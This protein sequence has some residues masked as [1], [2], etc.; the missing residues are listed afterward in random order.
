VPRRTRSRECSTVEASWRVKI[1]YTNV[2]SKT[3]HSGKIGVMQYK[4]RNSFSK[5]PWI[6]RIKIQVW[7]VGLVFNYIAQLRYT[8]HF[9]IFVPKHQIRRSNLHFVPK[10][11]VS[12]KN[13]S[14][15]YIAVYKKNSLRSILLH[16]CIRFWLFVIPQLHCML[17]ILCVWVLYIEPQLLKKILNYIR[18]HKAHTFNN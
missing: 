6:L 8:S 15:P 14:Y 7:T 13:Y 12:L 5:I 17:S 4:G 1:L 9:I 10:I 16:L 18:T 2:Y 3:L 11:G